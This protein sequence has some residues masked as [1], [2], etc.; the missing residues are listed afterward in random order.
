MAQK[1]YQTATVRGAI[2][3][4]IILAVGGLAATALNIWH[5][6]SQLTQD[7]Q[8]YKTEIAEKTETIKSL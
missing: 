6:R 4:G 8:N 7:N 1:W 3:G 2:I 5:D